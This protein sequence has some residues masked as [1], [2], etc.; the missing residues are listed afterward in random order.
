MQRILTLALVATLA[1]CGG[2]EEGPILP[3]PAPAWKNVAP[4]LNHA[5][6]SSSAEGIAVGDE[7][8]ILGQN[9]ITAEHGQQIL[10][11]RGTFFDDN[12]QS[13]AVNLQ[14]TPRHEGP[15]QLSW[16][17]WP[18]VVFHP[19]GNRIGQ[20][21]GAIEVINAGND[22]T[23]LSSAPLNVT[24]NVRPSLVVVHASPR[25]QGCQAVIKSTREE[26]S[27]GFT[28]E[29][30]G[31][32]PGTQD[33]PLTFYWTFLNEQWDIDWGFIATRTNPDNILPPK[34]AFML[35]DEARAGSISSVEPGGNN[36]LL[37]IWDK[38]QGEY[39][40]KDI[41]T[42]ALEGQ[43]EQYVANVNIAVKDAGGKSAR[44]NIP[45]VVNRA[46]VM[47][48]DGTQ[49]TAER[50]PPQKVAADCIP[51]GNIGR[52]VSWREDTSETRQRGMSFNMNLSV[53]TNLGIPIGAWAFANTVQPS[54][55]FGI[56]VNA[57]IST[58]ESISKDVSLQLLPVHYATFYRQTTKI[59]KTAKYWGQTVCGERVEL[60]EATLIDWI[61]TPDIAQSTQC[62]PASNLPPAQKFFDVEPS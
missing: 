39:S 15:S 49:K 30:V 9:F 36:V 53:S 2:E 44:L 7:L 47:V 43:A 8:M 21:V 4:T 22:G 33:A 61:F 57:S 34:G 58:T 52:Q 16:K 40:V 27:M 5:A 17:M 12:G 59:A 25:N 32:R 23:Q 19:Q 24:L 13:H 31:L 55:A 60:G 11:F 20:F 3:T 45:L 46:V 48:W 1:A 14:Y 51:G 28:V 41:R 50:F 10:V 18:N 6:S 62:P 26:V 42:R 37:Q 56:D 35:I 38:L 29:A 54:L